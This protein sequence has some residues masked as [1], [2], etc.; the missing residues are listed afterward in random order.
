MSIV[1][2]KGWT[3]LHF[4]ASTGQL[5]TIKCLINYIPSDIKTPTGITAYDI[6]KIN[7][8]QYV[9]DYFEVWLKEN[10]AI[11]KFVTSTQN[12]NTI[13]N[14]RCPVCLEKLF[15]QNWGLI[16][17]DTIHIGFCETCTKRLEE[18]V[19]PCPKCRAS[20]EKSTKTCQVRTKQVESCCQICAEKL[21]T[22]NWG[23]V[24]GD[25]MHFGYCKI[26]ANRLKNAALPKCPDCCADIETV[27]RVYN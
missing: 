13:D 23:L 22:E 17:G 26:C 16:H 25:S 3:A 9:V 6:A 20:I 8:R 2:S 24:H 10:N 11:S 1:S 15:D 7:Y 27:L 18:D 21:H 19:L 4:A 14:E 12:L 5:E